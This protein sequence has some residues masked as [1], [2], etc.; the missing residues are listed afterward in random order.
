MSVNWRSALPVTAAI[1]G[2]P[3]HS[4][5][6]ERGS[7]T[8]ALSRVTARPVHVHVLSGQWVRYQNEQ[9]FQ[10]EVVLHD[11]CHQYGQLQDHGSPNIIYNNWIYAVTL[12]PK[13][14]LLGPNRV[15]RQLANR[16]LGELLFSR[17]GQR[18]DL[19]FTQLSASGWMRR[20]L[21]AHHLDFQAALPARRSHFEFNHCALTVHEIVLPSLLRFLEVS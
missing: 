20:R 13:T 5:L 9:C 2:G 11:G 7:F 12:I 1:P 15:L 21:A 10:R 14:S 6:R 3:L 4:L 8:Q 18:L 16:P 17:R 19:A